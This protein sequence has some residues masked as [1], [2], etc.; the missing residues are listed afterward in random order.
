MPWLVGILTNH[1]R[2]LKRERARQAALPTVEER[3]ADP[4][5]AVADA[6]FAG[7][8]ARVRGA[9]DEP[10]AWVLDLHLGEGLNAKEIAARLERPA[11]T[12]RTQLV[13]GLRQLRDRLSGGAVAVA[14]PLALEPATR[15][16][17]R[18][19]LLAAT[20]NIPWTATAATA[21]VSTSGVAVAAGGLV[22]MRQLLLV[23]P[24]ALLLLGT[25]ATSLRT[26][27]PS[28]RR[29]RAARQ[30]PPHSR[31]RWER[32]NRSPTRPSLQRTEVSTTPDGSWIVRG[33]IMHGSVGP[34]PAAEIEGRAYAGYR[35]T[36]TPLHVARLLRRR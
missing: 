3:T 17:I 21:S 1:A 22:T 36:G 31:T 2:N 19:S 14:A 13:R 27:T 34:I 7:A 35:A 26:P 29:H 9:L 28:P 23:I 5:R 15:L 25:A 20:Q 24:A 6:E 11:G 32:S 4:A 30:R 18:S 10:Y 33:E 12:V 8:V 16:A